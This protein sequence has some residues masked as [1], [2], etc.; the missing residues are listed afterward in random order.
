MACWLKKSIFEFS[1]SPQLSPHAHFET[2]NSY[3]L[4]AFGYRTAPAVMV[5]RGCYG[6]CVILGV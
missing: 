1:F 6:G 4:A 5:P 2:T 3:T